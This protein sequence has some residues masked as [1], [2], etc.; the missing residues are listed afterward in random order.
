MIRLSYLLPLLLLQ[1]SQS[2]LT[3]TTTAPLSEAHLRGLS[4]V[5]PPEAFTTDP[6]QEV[7]A[8]GAGWIAV[9]P[10]AYTRPGTPDV[11][12]NQHQRQWWGERPEGVRRTLELAREANISVLMKPQVY[13]PGSWPGDLQFE[14]EADWTAWETAYRDYLMQHVALA[15][16]FGVPILC[17]GT[18]F[19]ISAVERETFW[20]TLIADIRSQ[21]P[22]RLTY[23]ANW[24]HYQNIP[25]W[26]A[27]DYIGIDAYFPLSEDPDP[28]LA[29]LVEAWQQPVQEVR[30]FQKKTDR[31]VIFTEFGYLS[32][33]GAA[34]KTWE[35]ESKV[36]SLDIDET[37]QATALDALFT[38]WSQEPYWKGGFLWKWFP[39]M[40]GHEGYRA[41]DYTPQG[42]EA[43]TVLRRWYAQKDSGN[44]KTD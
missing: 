41:R 33:A 25:F 37:E 32:V 6:M 21:Y 24:D 3:V 38:V 9:I 15:T 14:T 23:A 17:I 4:F 44:Q 29:Q 12:Y 43:M 36:R 26:D 34:G 42:K 11:Y 13:L 28:T 39:N 40:R 5:A 7:Q 35:L 2:P 27:L 16:E 1:C 19:K 30:A 22:G 18:E 8:A 20:R 31:P 10:Y